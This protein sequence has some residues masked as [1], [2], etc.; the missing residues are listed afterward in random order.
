MVERQKMN[1]LSF[2]KYESWESFWMPRH[3]I[4]TNKEMKPY[5]E[6]LQKPQKIKKGNS[7]FGYLCTQKRG[8]KSE[9][10]LQKRERVRK[11]ANESRSVDF[12]D[13]EG[14]IIAM[15]LPGSANPRSP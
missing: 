13:P 15:I 7:F 9:T 4:L 5:K 6:E 2:I 3:A 14:P 12:P 8:N 10:F 1:H 11:P